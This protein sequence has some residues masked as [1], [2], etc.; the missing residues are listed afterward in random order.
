MV[1]LDSAWPPAPL[2]R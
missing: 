1:L 2:D